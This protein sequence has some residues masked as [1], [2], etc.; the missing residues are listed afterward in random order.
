MQRCCLCLLGLL[1]AICLL[2][3]TLSAQTISFNSPE[4]YLAPSV[5]FAIGDFNNDGKP[6]IVSGANAVVMLAGHGDG[7]FAKPVLIA[8]GPSGAVAGAMVA[9]DFNRDGNLDVSIA[10]Y[11]SPGSVMVLLGN[12]NGTFKAPVSYP[13]GNLPVALVAAEFTGDNVLDL[14]A[15]DYGGGISV[16]KGNSNGTFQAAVHSQTFLVQNLAAAKFN[17]DAF[18]DLAVLDSSTHTVTVLFGDG[19]G[20]FQTGPQ[21]GA[22]VYNVKA[23]DVNNDQQQDLVTLE[24]EYSASYAPF[25]ARVYLGSGD[26]TFQSPKSSQIQDSV[27]IN[28]QAGM[29]LIDLNGDGK[30]DVVAELE[31]EDYGARVRITELGNG[32]GTFTEMDLSTQV[33]VTGGVNVAAADLNGDSKMDVV[34]TAT[35]AAWLSIQL[36]QGDG[37]FQSLAPI[38]GVAAGNVYLLVQ[39]AD[40]NKD[41]KQDILTMASTSTLT[42]G[43]P[44]VFLGKG[45]GTFQPPVSSNIANLG[46]PQIA[47]VNGD[48]IPDLIAMATEFV[49]QVML[50]KGD[51]TF[52]QPIQT[53]ILNTNIRFTS[54]NLTFGDFNGDSILDVA[55]GVQSTSGKIDGAIALF[56]GHGDGTFQGPLYLPGADYPVYLATGDFNHDSK[57]DIAIVNRPVDG[58]QAF[59]SILLNT[60]GGTFKN[61]YIPIPTPGSALN[62]AVGDFN[63]DS[64]DDLLVGGYAYPG[65][66]AQPQVPGLTVLL[67]D[68]DGTFHVSASYSLEPF[69]QSMSPIPLP[70]IADFDGDSK[71]DFVTSDGAN[72][73]F[74]KGGGDGTFVQQAIFESG[75]IAPTAA[76]FNGDSKPDLV[77]SANLLPSLNTFSGNFE[78]FLLTNTTH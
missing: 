28:S 40:F 22:Y 45:D 29:V 59:L 4:S 60:G 17:A 25:D 5:S 26:G 39:A 77:S 3:R 48:G 69:F 35:T 37:T 6:D 75:A 54:G 2:T 36:G 16:L 78:L 71:L 64:R 23:G 70:V 14:I 73:L 56:L 47:D 1:G 52:Q 33:P 58:T 31:I 50:G 74:W 10:F 21:L 61:S 51:G 19:S 30:L 20:N 34:A 65:G 68:G 57:P 41:G 46:A 76:D 18:M 49:F 44:T 24:Q 12:G 62:V 38:S 7:S 72:M 43:I 66:S 55:I 15:G 27:R 63:G 67:S 13:V 42:N 11:S 32:D 9:G 53:S 8:T